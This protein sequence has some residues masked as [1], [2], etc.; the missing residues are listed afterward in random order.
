MAFHELEGSEGCYIQDFRKTLQVHEVSCCIQYSALPIRDIGGFN[1][2]RLLGSSN[3]DATQAHNTLAALTAI[4]KETCGLLGVRQIAFDKFSFRLIQSGPSTPIPDDGIES[5]IVLSYTWH[6][7]AWKP[8]SSIVPPS[9]DSNGPLTPAMWSAFLAQAQDDECFWVDQLCINQFSESEKTTAVA[10]MDLIYQSARKVVIALEDVAISSADSDLLVIYVNGECSW[11]QTSE[12]DRTKLALA[13]KKIVAARWFNRA[14]CLHEFLVSRRHVFLVPIW[15]LDD[16][17][18]RKG[19][20]AKIIRIAGSFLVEMYYLFIKQDIKDKDAGTESLLHS[21]YLTG[22]EIDNIR[23]FFKHLANVGLQE[24]FG[25]RERPNDGSY[26]FMFHEVFSH[27]AVLDADKFSIILN[28]M[29]SGLYL[30]SSVT[31][32]K[33]DCLWLITLI[34]LAAGDATALTTT[35]PR[36]IGDKERYGKNRHWIRSP[37]GADQARRTGAITVPRT[38]IDVK[39]VEDGLELE[40]LFFGAN[41]IL[42]SPSHHY[43]SIARWLIDHRSLCKVALDENGDMRIDMEADESIYAR[44]RIS[45]IQ[46][47]A[48]A[49]A[50]GK[51]WMVGYYAKSYCSL[52]IGMEFHWSPKALET[53]TGAI[54][55]ALSTVIDGDIDPDLRDEWQD[56]GTLMWADDISETQKEDT[57][58]DS[59]DRSPDQLD[60]EAQ[61]WYSYLL[62]LTE[63]LVSFGLA[64]TAATENPETEQDPWN[65][66]ICTISGDSKF[67]VCVPT[68]SMEERL[69][70]GVPKALR[71]D[72]YSWMSRVWLLQE[73]ASSSQCRRFSLRGKS[74]LAGNSALPI[75]PGTRVTIVA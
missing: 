26:M 5:F 48:C 30:K 17:N 8:H 47:L 24:V 56:A 58:P 63:I 54:D 20:S 59:P 18:P 64:T 9:Q 21:G 29:R 61:V 49:L 43:L 44:L 75:I 37:S 62:D 4:S 39:V 52:P 12:N 19:L 38:T 55:W 3:V 69:H 32:D 6:S 11:N 25:S 7:S 40:I 13:F 72:A 60:E 45:Y 42:T 57:S 28:I 74:R 2:N 46:T 53:F 27:N 41:A 1:K 66:Q 15:Q 51:E 16:A 50:C 36:P 33:D 67:L 14:W 34:A 10:S 65:V 70:L 68:N 71:D 22:M 35:G 73:H 23:R 31:L